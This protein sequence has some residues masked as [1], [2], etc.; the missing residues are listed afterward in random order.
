MNNTNTQ[1]DHYLTQGCGRCALAG[2]P[3][4]K[5]NSWQTELMLLRKLVLETKLTETVKW[6]VPCYTHNNRNIVII[7][8]FKEYCGLLFFKGALLKDPAKILIQQTEN[9]QAG[10]Q[11]RFTQLQQIVELTHTIKE[12]IA[13]AIAI[14]KAGLKIPQKKTEDFTVPEEF[15]QKLLE[16]P[17]LQQAFTALTPGRQRGYLL[18]FAAPKQS[19]T[20]VSRIK[21]CVPQIMAGLGLHDV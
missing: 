17:L 6:G 9:V 14:E 10:R 3:Q 21:K 20:R 5:T 4:C 13:E 1:V 18:H 8:A 2:T 7:H 12:Y 16:L 15:Q 11:I 19:K